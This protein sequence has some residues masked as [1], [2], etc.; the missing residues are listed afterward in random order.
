MN[1]KE[2][3]SLRLQSMKSTRSS[4]LFSN[5]TRQLYSFDY[6]IYSL[7]LTLKFCQDRYIFGSRFTYLKS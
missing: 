3:L 7:K 2:D 6:R 5:I 1:K 4:G